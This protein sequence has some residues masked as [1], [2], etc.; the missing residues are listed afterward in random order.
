[1]MWFFAVLVVLAMGGV[2]L[3]AAGRGTPMSAEY[4]DRPDVVVPGDREVDA[5]DLR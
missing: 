4:D 2:A 1:M 5:A 3:I